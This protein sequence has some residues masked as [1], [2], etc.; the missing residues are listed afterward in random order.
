MYEAVLAF[1]LV[2]GCLNKACRPFAAIMVANMAVNYLIVLKYG[3]FIWVPAVDAAAFI[4]MA[5]FTLKRP[6]WWSF[7]VCELAFAAVVSHVV[8]WTLDA[9]G[10]YFGPQYQIVLGGAFILSALV[11]VFGG[12]DGG[13]LVGAAWRSLARTHDQRRRHGYSGSSAVQDHR[14]DAR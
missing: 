2:L 11:L 12:Y 4:G 6:S 5:W 1:F 8:Y 9:F 3:L 10:L 7:L 13:K 14:E